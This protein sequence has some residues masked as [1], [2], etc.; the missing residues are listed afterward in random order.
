MED[1]VLL[2]RLRRRLAPLARWTPLFPGLLLT[3]L[4]MLS[5]T[6]CSPVE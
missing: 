3:L 5:L 6:G 2:A 1:T 4:L